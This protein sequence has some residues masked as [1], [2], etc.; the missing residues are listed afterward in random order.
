MALFTAAIG[1]LTFGMI[2]AN[3]DGWAAPACWSTL[4]TGAVLLLAFTIAESRIHQPLLDLALLRNSTFSGVL[5]AALLLNLAA[6]VSFAY[7]SIWMQ[8]VLGLTPITAGIVGLPMSAAAFA[9]SATLGR[10]MHRLRA[11]NVI[12]VG[13]LLIGIGDLLGAV[14]VHE[15]ASWP[16]LLPGFFVVGIGVGTATPPL[17]ATGMS[18]APPDRAGMAA[19]AINTARQVGFA[20]GIALLG[21]VFTT[22]AQQTLTSSQVP[23][24]NAIAHAIASGRAAT[25]ET[26]RTLIESAA[27]NGIQ[28]LLTT[29][30]LAGIAAAATAL[31][32]I[33]D[34]KKPKIPAEVRRHQPQA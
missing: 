26:S 14:L 5:I 1:T 7:T 34:S 9:V 32:M 27:A 10:M 12:S 23:T 24:A 18:A 22:G 3:E 31:L 15:S 17:N 33:K 20:F 30:G 25:A 4:V 11:R 2:R 29:A 13:I 28:A 21:G 19:G 6:Y 8:S 16:A